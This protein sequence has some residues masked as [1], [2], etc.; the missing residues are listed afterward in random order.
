MTNLLNKNPLVTGAIAVLVVAGAVTYMVRSG[1]A[2]RPRQPVTGVWYLDLVSGELFT[3]KSD[4]LPPIPTDQDLPN[5]EPAGVLA[6]VRSC[7]DCDDPSQRFIAWVEKYTPEAKEYILNPQPIAE[8][9]VD[10]LMLTPG[11]EG[12]LIALYEPGVSWDQL[13]WVP[14]DSEEGWEVMGKA[15]ERCD[16]GTPKECTP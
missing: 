7:G 16:G 10:P 9:K 11:E 13:D 2:R 12:N 14:A 1:A 5:G 6:H 4:Q 15:R 3:A 8:E